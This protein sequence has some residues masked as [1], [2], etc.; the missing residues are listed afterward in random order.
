[1]ERPLAAAAAAAAAGRRGGGVL[2]LDRLR[3]VET[4]RVEPLP[5]LWDRSSLRAARRGGVRESDRP[6]REAAA[7]R[8]GGGDLDLDRERDEYEEPV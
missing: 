3:P 6:R 7:P 5:L 8:R 2:D 1:M 4:D